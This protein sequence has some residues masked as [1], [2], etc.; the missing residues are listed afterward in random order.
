MGDYKNS[1]F[2]KSLIIFL[3]TLFSC[4]IGLEIIG[5]F[6]LAPPWSLTKRGEAPPQRLALDPDI[7]WV[8]K[9]GQYLLGSSGK[10]TKIPATILPDSSRLTAEPTKKTERTV[11]FYGGSL[12][13]GD[14]V[15]DNYS[16]PYKV[17]EKL[18]DTQVLNYG[19]SAYGTHQSYLLMKRTL[20]SEKKSS[21]VIYGFIKHHEIRNLGTIGWRRFLALSSNKITPPFPYSTLDD[22][23]KLKE[24]MLP[25]YR[26]WQIGHISITFELLQYLLAK[27][28]INDSHED[29]LQ[30][31]TQK[32]I[33]KMRALAREHN[34]NFAVMLLTHHGKS[35]YL[36]FLKKEGVHVIDCTRT[37]LP[38]QI[39]RAN[40][41]PTHIIHEEWAKCFVENLKSGKIW[42]SLDNP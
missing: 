16:F 39:L 12:T 3:S 23:G 1:V 13:F 6:K 40:G 36:A 38:N 15:S 20:S 8:N 7:G 19:T 21:L 30:V 27:Y 33:L 34:S 28:L 5:H 14:G 26:I 4:I 29:I 9:P 10:E 37:I 17:G 18:P 25:V 32:T 35:D 31:V 22:E 2:Q 42:P 41:H 24:E 11:L